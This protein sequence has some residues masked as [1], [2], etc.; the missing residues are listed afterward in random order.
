MPRVRGPEEGYLLINL[1]K[2]LRNRFNRLC[3]LQKVS[4]E[5]FIVNWM[6]NPEG[7][8]E[9]P[10]Y[11]GNRKGDA[12]I[13]IVVP[14]DLREKFKTNCKTLKRSMTGE[15]ISMIERETLLDFD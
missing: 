3:K 14:L 7:L 1:P 2:E 5:R 13:R 8:G 12:I 6:K 11:L 9:S 15:I 10:K 4:A